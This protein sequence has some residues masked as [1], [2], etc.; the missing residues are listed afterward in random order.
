MLEQRDIDV[1]FSTISVM[2]KISPERLRNLWCVGRKRGKKGADLD[3][4]YGSLYFIFNYFD[5]YVHLYKEWT[6]EKAILFAVLSE[7]YGKGGV[8]GHFFLFNHTRL[9]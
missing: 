4:Y 5:F 2:E 6:E 7:V 1:W 8:V 9:I 3:S